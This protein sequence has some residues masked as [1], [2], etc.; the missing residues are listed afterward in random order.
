[1]VRVVLA[2]VVLVRVLVMRA[3]V[4]VVVGVSTRSSSAVTIAEAI[5]V[6]EA[7]NSLLKSRVPTVGVTITIPR[8]ASVVAIPVVAVV[9]GVTIVAGVAIV[10]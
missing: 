6:S 8:V 3:L 4:V 7:I 1:M 5:V 10:A 9:A 2:G